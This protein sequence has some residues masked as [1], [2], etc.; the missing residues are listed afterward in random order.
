[1]LVVSNNLLNNSVSKPDD[2]SEDLYLL[3]QT[4]HLKISLKHHRLM[5]KRN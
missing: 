3:A 4:I 1:M 2:G 5:V